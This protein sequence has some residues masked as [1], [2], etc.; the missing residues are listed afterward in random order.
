MRAP[1]AALVLITLACRAHNSSESRG[2]RPADSSP[3]QATPAPDSTSARS[4]KPTNVLGALYERLTAIGED[5]ATVRSRLGEPRLTTTAA[6][7]NVHDATATDTLVEWS[8]DHLHFKFLVTAGRDLLVET[9]AA[10]DYPAVALLIGQFSTLEAAEATFGAPRWTTFLADTMV[11]GYSVPEPDIGASEN[12]VNFYFKSGR[13][14][15]VAVEPY[16]D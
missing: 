13:L 3:L 15:F 1:S 14:I 4:P 12:T 2:S 7:P 5:R 8:F 6:E 9:R 16:V 10:T 11:Y